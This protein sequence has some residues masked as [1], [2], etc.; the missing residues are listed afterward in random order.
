MEKTVYHRYTAVKYY[1]NITKKDFNELRI[2]HDLNA[3]ASSIFHAI[4]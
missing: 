1:R 3:L 2:H 4:N